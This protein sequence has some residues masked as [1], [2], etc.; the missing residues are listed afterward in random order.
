MAENTVNI[1]D[2]SPLQ[3]LCNL[4]ENR[5]QLATNHTATVIM[6]KVEK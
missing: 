6:G 3:L 4:T 1:K 5:P 2:C